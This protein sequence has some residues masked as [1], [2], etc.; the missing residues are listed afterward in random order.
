VQFRLR[1]SHLFQKVDLRDFLSR[2]GIANGGGHPGAIGFRFERSQII[3]MNR[4][5]TELVEKAGA[6]VIDAMNS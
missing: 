1:R 4:F 6:M 2:N 5:S 3:D